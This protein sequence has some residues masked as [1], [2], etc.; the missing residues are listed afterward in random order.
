MKKLICIYYI[1]T[2][3]IM[4]NTVSLFGYKKKLKILFTTTYFPAFDGRFILN[5]ITGCIDAGHN[6]LIYAKHH[7]PT[8]THKNVP[9]YKLLQRTYYGVIPPNLE[10]FDIIFSQFGYCGQHFARILKHIPEQSRPKLVTYFRGADI[11]KYLKLDPHRYDELF[12]IGSLF[13]VVCDYFKN[14]LIRAG[15]DP[16]KIKVL[17][18][19]IDCDAFYFKPP[20]WNPEE[21]YNIITVARLVEKKG[22]DYA[23]RA[24]DLIRKI[25]PNIHYYIIGEGEMH[26]ELE[27]LVK[28]LNLKKHVT[29]LGRLQEHAIIVLLHKS[30]VFLLP[31]ITAEN[32]DQEGIPNAAKE[33]MA[34][35]LPVIL[36]DHAGNSELVI[37]ESGFLIEERNISAIVEKIMYLIKNPHV[38]ERMGF[39]GRHHVLAHFEMNSNNKKL[40]TIFNDLINPTNHIVNRDVAL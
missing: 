13:F 9:K 7:G 11:T 24:I 16:S 14:L 35:G 21:T 12:K 2:L 27:N 39:A 20:K 40:V 30:H 32:G 36:T 4:M 3:F 17:H 25:H 15:C 22:I 37:P 19:S 18:S 8:S 38:W 26:S 29:F 10:Q 28:R 1:F 34:C 5:M 33:A 23:I 31:S 6:V